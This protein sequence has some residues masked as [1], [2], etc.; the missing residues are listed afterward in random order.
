L[1]IEALYDAKILYATQKCRI[2][3]EK[4]FSRHIN[5]LDVAKSAESADLQPQKGVRKAEVSDCAG[6]PAG[7]SPKGNAWAQPHRKTGLHYETCARGYTFN[8]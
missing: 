2:C 6:K 3:R 4:G 1:G 5:R 7:H 8:S